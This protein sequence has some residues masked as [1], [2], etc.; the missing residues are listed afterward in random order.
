M[1]PPIAQ[2]YLPNKSNQTVNT[3]RLFLFDLPFCCS[4]VWVFWCVLTFEAFAVCVWFS[5]LLERRWI[6]SCQH[7]ALLW[8]SLQVASDDIIACKNFRVSTFVHLHICML[9]LCL[10]LVITGIKWCFGGHT[11]QIRCEDHSVHKRVSVFL[12]LAFAN[13]PCTSWVIEKSPI[14]AWAHVTHLLIPSTLVQE[15][16]TYLWESHPSAFTPP[17]PPASIIPGKR[18]VTIE[19]KSEKQKNKTTDREE[20]KKT[21]MGGKCSRRKQGVRQDKGGNNWENSPKV[22][23]LVK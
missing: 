19:I 20:R 3:L 2:T 17:N 4:C 12:L 23:A 7:G 16:P 22:K 8:T 21:I 15:F 13:V 14:R 1:N 6:G 9:L 5:C 10:C 11:V 18:T